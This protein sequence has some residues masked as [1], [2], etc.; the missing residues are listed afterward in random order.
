M[1]SPVSVMAAPHAA[2]IAAVIVVKRRTEPDEELTM[3]A[4]RWAVTSC[5]HFVMRDLHIG[6]TP[7]SGCRTKERN[8]EDHP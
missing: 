5:Y 7:T 6:H 1:I 8:H 4:C 3:S 2:L